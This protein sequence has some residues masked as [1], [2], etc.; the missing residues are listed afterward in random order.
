[1]IGGIIPIHRFKKTET[2]TT[3]KNNQISGNANNIFNNKYMYNCI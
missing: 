3:K 2:V 1:M